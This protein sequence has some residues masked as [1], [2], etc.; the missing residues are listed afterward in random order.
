MCSHTYLRRR[1]YKVNQ[2]FQLSLPGLRLISSTASQLHL[3]RRPVDTFVGNNSSNQHGFSTGLLQ[4]RDRYQALVLF[5]PLWSHHILFHD[6]ITPSLSLYHRIISVWVAPVQYD[7]SVVQAALCSMLF[8]V[9]Q[10]TSTLDPVRNH[11]ACAV[12]DIKQDPRHL[13]FLF[14]I[15]LWRNKYVFEA[16]PESNSEAPGHL[17]FLYISSIIRRLYIFVH[18]LDTTLHVTILLCSFI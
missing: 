8:T 17:R 11:H 18:R 15:W 1:I 4:L 14:V 9:D 7:V 5:N 2:H 6:W 16:F 13:L 3:N 12:E 10:V